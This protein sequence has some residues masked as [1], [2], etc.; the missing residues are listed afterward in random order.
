MKLFESKAAEKVSKKDRK[1]IVNIN[2][3]LL[4][5]VIIVNVISY[6]F[7]PEYMTS[8]VGVNGKFSVNTNNG[9]IL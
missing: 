8:H 3:I 2:V 9:D 1:K 7:L 5:I 4:L 6:R